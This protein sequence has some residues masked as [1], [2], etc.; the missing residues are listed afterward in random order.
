MSKV[1]PLN[2][3]SGIALINSFGNLSGFASPYLIGW[4]RDTTRSTDLGVYALAAMLVTGALL[5]LFRVP[6]Q[7]TQR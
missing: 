5:V 1:R 4:I 3:A 2:K 6:A 7:L